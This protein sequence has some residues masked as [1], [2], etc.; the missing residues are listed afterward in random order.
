MLACR[1]H[2]P[3]STKMTD[4]TLEELQEKVKVDSIAVPTPDSGQVLI[5]VEKCAINPADLSTLKGTYGLKEG[6]QSGPSQLGMEGC[7]TVVS[8]GG[9]L[10]AWRLVGKRVAFISK[11]CGWAQYAVVNATQCIDIEN[12]PWENAT[13]VFVNPMTVMGFIEMAQSAGQSAIVHTAAASALGKMLIRYGKRVGIEIICVVRKEE[14]EQTCRNLG[15]K[16]VF[17]SNDSEF[18]TKLREACQKTKCKMAFDAVAGSLTGTILNALVD[19]G[20]VYVYG[21][22]SEQP[23]SQ[24]SPR[25]LIFK[26]KAV[27]GFWMSEYVKSKY[28]LGLLQWTWTIVPLLTSD[29]A[30]DVI[31]E[32]KLEEIHQGILKYAK[33]MSSGKIIVNCNYQQK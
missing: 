32:V 7:G 5:R 19:G 22:L 18:L 24:I 4:F 17:N 10:L 2:A 3:I 21:G 6:T 25:D 26:N 15:A 31:G 16:Y 14:A 28:K 33:N 30:S 23:I 12:T 1:L 8:S 13:S 11:S 29:F 27:K 9:G 20:E